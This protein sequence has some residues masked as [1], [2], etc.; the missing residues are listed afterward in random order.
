MDQPGVAGAGE[1]T[2]LA[3]VGDLGMSSLLAAG[4]LDG[5]AVRRV[6][7]LNVASCDEATDNLA[8][9]HRPEAERADAGWCS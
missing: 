2:G 6:A 3:E 7:S 1:A 8:L 4:G 5:A 9:H